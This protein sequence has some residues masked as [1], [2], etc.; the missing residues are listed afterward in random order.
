[1]DDATLV[2]FAPYLEKGTVLK[3]NSI[4]RNLTQQEK[5]TFAALRQNPDKSLLSQDRIPPEYIQNI[6]HNLL[7]VKPDE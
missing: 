5:N 1:M 7:E 4:P 2:R 6:M 3:N